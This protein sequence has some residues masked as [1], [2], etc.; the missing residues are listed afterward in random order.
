MYEAPETVPSHHEIVF[1]A[2]R[3]LQRRQ[4][5]TRGMLIVGAF[6]VQLLGYGSL[7]KAWW[8]GCVLALL[9]FGTVGASMGRQGFAC[10]AD[11]ALC[12]AFAKE[13]D[14]SLPGGASAYVLTVEDARKT[15]YRM[16]LDRREGA[17]VTLGQPI[18]ISVM[19][20][21]ITPEIYETLM[22]SLI[23]AYR[24]INNF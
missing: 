9:C 1:S 22:A 11:P 13:A 2:D 7:M 4:I 23:R 15:F 24:K 12:A 19:D 18:S 6:I 10:N 20:R 17:E 3:K 14:K 21:Q 5:P 8:F 16:R